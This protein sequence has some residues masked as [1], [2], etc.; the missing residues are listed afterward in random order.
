MTRFARALAWA[1]FALTV[2]MGCLGTALLFWHWDLPVPSNIFA[3]RGSSGVVGAVFCVMGVVLA[4]RRP[5]NPIGWYLSVAGLGETFQFTSLEYVGLQTFGTTHLPFIDPLISLQSWMWLPAVMMC[6]TFTFLRYPEGQLLSPGWRFIERLA[7]IATAAFCGGLA[8]VPGPVTNLGTVPNP[9]GLTTPGVRTVVDLGAVLT[10]A[11]VV[12]A[13]ISLALRARRGAAME[14]AQI[15]WLAYAACIVGVLIF[16]TV[17]G[18]G[19]SLFPHV[20]LKGLEDAL[21]VSVGTIPLAVGFAV[22]RYRLYDID[23]LIRRTAS[24]ALATGALVGVY[25]GLVALATQVLPL[26]GTV[27]TA[28]S[29]LVAVALFNPLRQRV[30]H[31]VDRRFNRERYNAEATVEAFA[32]RLREEVALESVRDDLVSVVS[33]TVQPRT[34]SVWLRDQ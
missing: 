8:L 28:A 1:L 32:H 20:V 25:V 21:I 23:R 27:G 16:P 13:A 31:G 22:L 14:R 10:L 15:K 5:R 30:Q 18:D 33:Q 24:Y 17:A 19:F 12:L 26:S 6:T 34:I 2:S 11:C 9:Y 3:F 29:V 4:V 7:V